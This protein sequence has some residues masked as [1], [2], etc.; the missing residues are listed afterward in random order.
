MARQVPEIKVIHVFKDG[1]VTTDP[2][3]RYVPAEICERIHEI[4]EN[5]RRRQAREAAIRNGA[6]CQFSIDRSAVPPVERD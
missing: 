2:K 6:A 4:A 1:L 3:A 5:I